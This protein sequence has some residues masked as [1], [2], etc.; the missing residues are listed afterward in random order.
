MP[1]VC[2]FVPLAA[3]LGSGALKSD[4]VKARCNLVVRV[5]FGQN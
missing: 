5:H 2:F 3:Y 1:L 4:C